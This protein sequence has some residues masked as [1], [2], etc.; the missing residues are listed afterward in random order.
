MGLILEFSYHP[1]NLSSPTQKKT[2]WN[3]QNLDKN[4]WIPLGK[5]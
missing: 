2:L 4:T 1:I 3:Q 5:R